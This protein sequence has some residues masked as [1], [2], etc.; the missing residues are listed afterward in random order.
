MSELGVKRP[1]DEAEHDG[2]QTKKQRALDMSDDA[3]LCLKAC[4]GTVNDVPRVPP[5]LASCLDDLVVEK[6]IASAASLSAVPARW[7]VW[8]Y[9]E[10]LAFVAR[11]LDASLFFYWYV[12]R[13]APPPPSPSPSA[14]AAVRLARFR[15]ESSNLAAH[16]L[17]CSNMSRAQAHGKRRRC[18]RRQRVRRT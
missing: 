6:D 5:E 2:R 8:S 10:K 11:E 3:L 1:A 4:V 14:R 7:F 17:C 18:S 13:R 16:L 9:D 15:V 12:A